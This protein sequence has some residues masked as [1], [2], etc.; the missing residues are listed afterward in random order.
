[1]RKDG[2]RETIESIV[3]ALVLAFLFRTFEAEAF[4][5]PT[6]SMGPTLMGRHKDLDCPQCGF[7]FRVNAASEYKDQT[8]GYDKSEE[9]RSITCPMCR[10]TNEEVD[11]SKD[12]S[13][14]GDRLLVSKMAYQVADPERWDVIVFKYPEQAETNYIKR[15]IG[16]PGETV[17]IFQGDIFINKRGEDGFHIAQKPADKA[18]ATWQPVYDNDYA[19]QELLDAGWPPRWTA[20]NGVDGWT[21]SEDLKTFTVAAAEDEERRLTYE[22]V[23]PSWQDWHD[24]KAGTLTSDPHARPQLITDF[25]GYNSGVLKSDPSARPTAATLGLH[26]VSDLVVE[27]AI[28]VS[29]VGDHGEVEFELIKGGRP[30]TCKIDLASGEVTLAVE[31]FN[32]FT[33]K[34][35]SSISGTGMHEITFANIDQQLHVWVDGVPLNFDL[36]TSYADRDGSTPIMPTTADLTPVSVIARSASM[37]LTHLRVFRDVYYIAVEMNAG[38]ALRDYVHDHNSYRHGASEEMVDFLSSPELW[39]KFDTMRR[40]E[41][42]LDDDQFF[43]LGDNS[44]R[45]QDSRLWPSQHFLERDMLIGKAMVVYWPH[46][47]DEIPGTDIP[48]PFF[49]NFGAMRLV[50]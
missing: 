43:A 50:R 6:G 40:V 12:L 1:M 30:H 22:H 45:S 31:G 4:V 21:R 15:L 23:V 35:P 26:W 27:G 25:C 36:S 10:Y 17:R 9:I 44:P 32:D 46:S 33:P 3:I 7:H 28:D 2:F 34:A 37:S 20:D 14:N 19:Q 13:F 29:E 24:V 48:F 5:I 11:Y 8:G 47:W 39:G 18:R 42:K 16:L 41:F 38:G 49:P